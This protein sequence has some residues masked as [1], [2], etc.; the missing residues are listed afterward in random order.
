VSELER[1]LDRRDL[2]HGEQEKKMESL[3]KRCQEQLEEKVRELEK[4]KRGSRRES[5]SLQ[6]REELKE[7]N[8]I[9]SEAKAQINHLKN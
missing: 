4:L 3:E 6:V 5:E 2:A 8:E 7:K 1:E 9:I